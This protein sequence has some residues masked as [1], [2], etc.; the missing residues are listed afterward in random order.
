MEGHLPQD[1]PHTLLLQD[2]TSGMQELEDAVAEVQWCTD[3]C[4]GQDTF[5]NVVQIGG[6][7][8]NKSR[9]IAQHFRYM[10]LTSSTDRLHHVAQESCFKPTGHLGNSISGAQG[11][12]HMQSPMLSIHQPIT[13]LVVCEQNLFLCVA[14]VTGLFIDSRPVNDIPISLLPEKIVQMSYQALRLIPASYTDDPKGENDWR[15]TNLFALL[16]KVPGTLIQPINQAITT[17]NTCDSFFLFQSSIL[18]A[19]TSNLQ[20]HINR[21]HCK[22]IPH[23]MLSQEFPYREQQ[24]NV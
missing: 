17:H 10:T 11:D 12:A 22:A 6:I 5:S 24:G 16:N 1:L 14:E 23:V 4:E 7:M 13:T 20:D 9:A 2:S 18:I 8:M 3:L 15:S 21:G 19:I